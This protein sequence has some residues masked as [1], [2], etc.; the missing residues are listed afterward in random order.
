MK[1]LFI[2]CA[3]EGSS[4]QQVTNHPIHLHNHHNTPIRSPR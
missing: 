2:L 3:E 4:S 1:L